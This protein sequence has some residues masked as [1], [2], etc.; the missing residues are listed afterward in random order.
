[1]TELAALR[2]R[3]IVKSVQVR[4]KRKVLAS[5]P[6]AAAYQRH[7]LQPAAACNAMRDGKFRRAERDVTS[8]GMG[9]YTHFNDEGR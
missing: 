8:L 4:P 9:T 5:L 3:L 7:V 1:M 2:G 6:E